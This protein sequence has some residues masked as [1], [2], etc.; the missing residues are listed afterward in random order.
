VLF[1]VVTSSL[2][3]CCKGFI[4]IK[5]H[6]GATLNCCEF[7]LKVVFF[8]EAVDVFF[9]MEACVAVEREI[10]K[11]SVTAWLKSA[12]NYVANHPS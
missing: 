3:F 10:D 5:S 6:Q 8:C 9:Q 11:V 7:S 4:K 12:S 1:D 2:F